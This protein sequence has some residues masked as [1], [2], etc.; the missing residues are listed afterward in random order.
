MDLL[1]NLKNFGV[2]RVVYRKH[3]VDTYSEP[4]YFIIQNV[5]PDMANPAG[6]VN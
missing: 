2:G 4:S 3:I 5:D 1:C 6:K